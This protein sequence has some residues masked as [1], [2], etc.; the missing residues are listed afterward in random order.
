M[1]YTGFS[2][3]FSFNSDCITKEKCLSANQYIL[4]GECERKEGLLIRDLKGLGRLGVTRKKISLCEGYLTTG[5]KKTL[6]KQ[7]I[8]YSL[9]FSKKE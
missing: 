6:K 1:I 4:V 3:C 7:T 5:T 9:G 8:C 2:I